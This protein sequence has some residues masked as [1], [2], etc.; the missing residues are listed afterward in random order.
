MTYPE[1]GARLGAVRERIAL[2][3]E[4][5]GW[6]HPVRIIAVTKGHGPEAVRAAAA[7]GDRR[8]ERRAGRGEVLE[9]RWVPL[10]PSGALDHR[11]PIWNRRP[12]IKTL[13]QR[14]VCAQNRVHFCA[15][16]ASP[17]C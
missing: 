10:E 14:G 11:A 13:N 3:Q 16:R 12:M 2:A 5:A 15:R 9:R 7:A 4:R 8:L 6:S 17:K 1:L